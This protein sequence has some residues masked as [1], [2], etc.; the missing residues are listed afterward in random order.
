MIFIQVD[1]IVDEL[2]ELDIL[3][4][5]HDVS[6]SIEDELRA[7]RIEANTRVWDSLCVRDSLLRQKAKSR[8]LKKGDKNSRFFHPFLK[9]RFHRNNI[10]GLNV[11]GE[12]IDDVGGLRRWVLTISEIVFKSRS[13]IGL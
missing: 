3:V 9:V 1:R 13:L 2:N 4:A 5:S 12:I 8:W 11:E 6:P 10:V 7:R